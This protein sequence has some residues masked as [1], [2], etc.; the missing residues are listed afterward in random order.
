MS[1]E[2]QYDAVRRHG[3]RRLSRRLEEA[4][5]TLLDLQGLEHRSGPDPASY[6][7]AISVVVELITAVTE[8]AGEER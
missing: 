5:N 6:D 8:A 2:D 3:L 1:T 7:S 4:L